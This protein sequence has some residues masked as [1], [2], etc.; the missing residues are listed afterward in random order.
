[1]IWLDEDSFE[2]SRDRVYLEDYKLTEVYNKP[3]S[4]LRDE[5]TDQEYNNI[6][7]S[8]EEEYPDF[9]KDHVTVFGEYKSD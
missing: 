3:V 2:K 5:F 4:N 7:Y 8:Y 9:L 1:M 6:R